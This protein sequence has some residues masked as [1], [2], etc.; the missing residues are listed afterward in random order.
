[1]DDFDRVAPST[2]N[3]GAEMAFL[4]VFVIGLLLLVF[5]LF[6]GGGGGGTADPAAVSTET[7]PALEDTTP[8]APV[9]PATGN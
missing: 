8:T 1:M 7:A 4:I 9:A 5:A 2:S 3:G 6:A